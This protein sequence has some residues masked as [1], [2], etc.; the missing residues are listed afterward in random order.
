M[1]KGSLA[2]LVIRV[3]G[4]LLLGGA[5]FHM[6]TM[7]L[8]IIVNTILVTS[9]IDSSESIE[10]G[11]VRLP[12]IRWDSLLYGVLLLPIAFYFL[13][14]GATVHRWLVKE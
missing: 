14:Y 3:I 1:D 4:L 2:W 7:I 10:G 6:V 9:I 12:T 11:I 8:N 5:I 13:R